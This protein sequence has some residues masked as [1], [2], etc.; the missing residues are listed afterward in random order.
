MTGDKGRWGPGAY[1]G[2]WPSGQGPWDFTTC[3]EAP[4]VLVKCRLRFCRSEGPDSACLTAPQVLSPQF[5]QHILNNEAQGRCFRVARSSQSKMFSVHAQKVL[6]F[7]KKDS[8]WASLNTSLLSAY[9]LRQRESK[10]GSGEKWPWVSSPW[11]LFSD[12]VRI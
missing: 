1:L 7:G 11:Q 10:Q 8:I 5:L 3:M 2:L 6:L 4:G 9:L 12:S